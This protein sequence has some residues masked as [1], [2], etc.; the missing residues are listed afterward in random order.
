MRVHFDARKKAACRTNPAPRRLGL[1]LPG[2]PGLGQKRQNLLIKQ[3]P[4]HSLRIV[5]DLDAE[6]Q[7]RK[8]LQQTGMQVSLRQ[9]EA[10]PESAS[11]AYEQTNEAA[12]LLF[13][14][15][16]LPLLREEGWQIR[17]QPD[18]QYNL[19]Q[20]DDWYAEVEED[21]EQTWFD[22]ELG[23]EVEGQR[24]SLLPILLQAIRHKPWLL[25]G[26]ALNKRD[27]DEMLLVSLPHKPQTRGLAA[28]PLKPLLATLGG[29][30]AQARRIQPT[31]APVTPGCRTAEIT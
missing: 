3:S 18:F 21:P 14:R 4:T 24:I 26:E 7:L 27:D 30:R 13:V 9:S 10:L 25:N 16:Q 23:I 20:V 17:I 6:A 28:G 2:L 31:P 19:A 8:R 12:W 1:R 15:E 5:R 11:E 29:V 22:L